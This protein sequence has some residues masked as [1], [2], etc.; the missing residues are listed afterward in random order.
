MGE[1]DELPLKASPPTREVGA[2]DGESRVKA[3]LAKAGVT[4]V[5]VS[6]G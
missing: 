6:V 3:V 4:H 5:E 1:A 2:H